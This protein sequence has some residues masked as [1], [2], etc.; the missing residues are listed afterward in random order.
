MQQK[1]YI[2][3]LNKKGVE[4]LS[5]KKNFN[6]SKKINFSKE[7]ES[8]DSDDYED[9]GFIEGDVNF[10]K[11]I[12]TFNFDLPATPQKNQETSPAQIVPTQSNNKEAQ[13]QNSKP[14]P[15]G[16][17]PPI[18]GEQF[19]IKRCYQFR[20]STVR[21]LNKLKANHE[22]VNAYLSTILDE[23]ILHYYESFFNKNKTI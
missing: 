16:I 7:V 2:I 15:R 22:D 4:N 6:M 23:A 11:A 1:M 9:N 17:T 12:A 20:P 10:G 18:N 13:V 3:W 21:K 19:T 14:S 8:L 5:M